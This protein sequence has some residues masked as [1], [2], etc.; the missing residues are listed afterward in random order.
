MEQDVE[1]DPTQR[2]ERFVVRGQAGRFRI[3]DIWTGETAT[4]AM[5]AQDRLSE[6]DAWHTAGLLNRQAGGSPASDS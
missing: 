2:R 5:T 4:I 1:S 3:V 6:A